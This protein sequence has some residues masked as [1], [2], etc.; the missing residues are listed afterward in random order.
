M[1]P[2]SSSPSASGT[3]HLHGL[4]IKVP[5]PAPPSSCSRTDFPGRRPRLRW[6]FFLVVPIFELVL[7][8][9]ST[10]TFTRPHVCDLRQKKKTPNE[11]T[12]GTLLSLRI[13]LDR[14]KFI[15]FVIFI[16]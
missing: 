8:H 13:E 9:M 10:S 3:S 15:F 7:E 1:F 2:L 14:K 12:L 16:S 11:G 5:S 4:M 6:H